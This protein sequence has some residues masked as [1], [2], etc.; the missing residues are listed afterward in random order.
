MMTEKGL[1]IEAAGPAI[2]M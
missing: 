2:D 1:V